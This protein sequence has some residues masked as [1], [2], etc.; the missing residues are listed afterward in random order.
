MITIEE[1]WASMEAC[2]DRAHSAAWDT[3]VE[4][5]EAQENEEYELAEEL[6]DTA[7]S[8]Q[9]HYFNCELGDL[10]DEEYEAIIHYVKTNDDFREQ[11]ESYGGLIE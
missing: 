8:E 6:R 7:S 5:D 10:S 11:F 2:N 4:A 1:A 3:W 9:A